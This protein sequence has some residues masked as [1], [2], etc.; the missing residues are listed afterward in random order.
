MMLKRVD[1]FFGV[2]LI[3]M[4]TGTVLAQEPVLPNESDPAWRAYYWN[5]VTLSGTP[6]LER[7]ESDLNHDWGTGS[8]H[9]NVNVDHF[10]ARWTRYLYVTD[11]TYRFTVTSDD[12]IRVW[13][14]DELIINAWYDHAATTFSA[15]K[16]L[17]TGHHWVVVEFYENAGEA[18]VRLTWGSISAPNQYWHGEY[19][20]NTALSGTPAL[21]R[22]DTEIDFDW[23]ASSPAPGVISAD[24]FSV[25]WT[26]TADLPVG[27]YRFVMTAD[28]GAR[29]W[30]NNRLLIDA[31]RDQV[32][33]TYTGEIDLAGG[34]IPIKME[35]YE[36]AGLAVARL[37]WSQISTP[38]YNWRGEYY[39]NTTLSDNPS[40]IRNDTQI[41]FNWST[42]SPAPGI[43]GTD[44]F[45]VRWT[46]MLDLS[47][48]QYR[49]SITVD[50]GARLWVNNLLLIDA[51]REQAA[52]TYTQDIYLPSGA[53]PIQME[54][55]ENKG[56]AVARLSWSLIAKPAASGTVIVDDADPGFTKGGSVTGWRTIS[57]GYS[58]RL[59]WTWN[60]DWQR[61]NYNWAHWQPQ[62]T[63]GWYEVFVFIPERYTTTSSARYVIA[64]ADG[65][66][67]RAADQSAN[68]SQW[69]SLGTYR[70]TGTAI[71]GVTLTD[72]TGEPRLTRLIAFDAVK[73]EPR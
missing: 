16:R 59:L 6:A 19:W 23:G 15:E 48:G 30:V 11:G 58:G 57:E 20:N 63:A 24:G 3:L 68:G 50:D 28:D 9:P 46:R 44:H 62:L 2:A 70:F 72:A 13:A 56:Q 10:S 45:S 41:D 4:V 27:Q 49:F 67:T 8:P 17:S 7:Q 12:G 73:W 53:I 39:N 1:V 31:W 36:N 35:Y 54:Y 38:T 64:H 60:N 5:N 25:R 34:P 40:L 33:T 71:D 37:S 14:D 22:D 65:Y 66:T 61:P 18:V 69:V 29:L 51:W 52:T 47:G 26:L 43:I 55:Y 42:G 32:A 21:V